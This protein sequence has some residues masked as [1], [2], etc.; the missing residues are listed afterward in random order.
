MHT[1]EEDALEKGDLRGSFP[2]QRPRLGH[3][4]PRGTFA[5]LHAPNS[6]PGK[7]AAKFHQGA[8]ENEC[9]VEPRPRSTPCTPEIHPTPPRKGRGWRSRAG[10]KQRQKQRSRAREPRAPPV[11][12]RLSTDQAQNPASASIHHP[13]PLPTPLHPGPAIPHRH[14]KNHFFVKLGCHASPP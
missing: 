10:P 3:Q 13:H 14:L 5:P 9:I 12:G 1:L 6:S 4:P 8:T 11:R 2:L 7:R